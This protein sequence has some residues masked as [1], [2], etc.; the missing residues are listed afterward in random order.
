MIQIA[1]AEPVCAENIGLKDIA[2]SR[3]GELISR[4]ELIMYYSATKNSIKN[5]FHR[6]H[7]LVLSVCP[8]VTIF[9]SISVFFQKHSPFTGQ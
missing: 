2:R 9:V 1:Q 5:E 3:R 7:N 8:F 4:G 6:E